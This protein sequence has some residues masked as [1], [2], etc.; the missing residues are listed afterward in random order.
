MVDSEGHEDREVLNVGAD[1][2]VMATWFPDGRRALVL[3]ETATHR[4]LGLWDRED[5]AL[6]WL[7]DDPARNIED[8]FVPRGSA[9]PV[10]VVVELAGARSHTTLLNVDSGEERRLPNVAGNL[11]PLRQLED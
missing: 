11:I 5:G 10:A 6:R 9:E 3:A 2:K 4:R 7:I 1:K 8:A